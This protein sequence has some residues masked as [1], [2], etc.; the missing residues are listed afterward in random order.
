MRKIGI[1][2]MYEDELRIKKI[3]E[4]AP[5]FELVLGKDVSDCEVVFGHLS[6]EQIKSAKKLKWLHAQSAGVDHYLKPEVGLP[7]DVILTNSAGMHGI[8]IAEHLL[9]FTL[10]LMRRMH[11]YMLQQPT[12]E[13]KHLGEIKS[14]YQSTIT[15]VGLGGIG[16]QYAER[17]KDLGATVRG[18]ARSLRQEDCVDEMYTT[19]QIDEAIKDADVVALIL[20]NTPETAGMFNRERMLKMKKSA[21]ILNAG[22]GDA[23]DQDAMIELLESGHLGGA[24]LDVTTPEPLPKDSKLWDLPNVVLTPHVSGGS[25]LPIV[26]DMIHER[27]VGYLKD[28][29]A[30]REFEKVVDKKAGY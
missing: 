7:Q 28:Y 21:L 13:W 2:H 12:H 5:G 20:P 3:A 15:V 14:I 26:G 16:R 30:G 19:D 1:T 6:P 10:M 24:G 27:F 29:V 9:A 8:S 25:S 4:A 18:V 11:S 23:I 17:C 22:R